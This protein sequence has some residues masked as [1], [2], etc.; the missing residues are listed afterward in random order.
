MSAT[1]YAALTAALERELAV[2]IG[3]SDACLLAFYGLTVEEL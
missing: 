3:R 1:S 2:E